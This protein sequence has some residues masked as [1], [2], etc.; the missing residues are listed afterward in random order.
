MVFSDLVEKIYKKYDYLS[1]ED[2]RFVVETFFSYIADT[3]KEGDEL[4][5]RDF[6]RF[7]SKTY[8][9]RL[10]IDPITGKKFVLGD[11]LVPLFKPSVNLNDYIGK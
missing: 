7:F 5:L 11:F 2:A 8:K 10:F 1:R 6:G 4:I 9:V 3:I